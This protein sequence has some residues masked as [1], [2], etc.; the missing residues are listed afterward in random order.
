[1]LTQQFQNFEKAQRIKISKS[2]NL[3]EPD[4]REEQFEWFKTQVEL[5]QKVF[6]KYTR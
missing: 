5:F 6:P 2:G 3:K 4:K 1:L